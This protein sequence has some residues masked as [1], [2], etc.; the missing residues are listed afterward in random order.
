MEAYVTNGQVTGQA[1]PETVAQ[2]L[3]Q[4]QSLRDRIA[5]VE[6]EL[7]G[8]R[9]DPAL[10]AELEAL[11]N[12]LQDRVIRELRLTH[13]D[14]SQASHAVVLGE[15]EASLLQDKVWQMAGLGALIGLALSLGLVLWWRPGRIKEPAAHENLVKVPYANG[16]VAYANDHEAIFPIDTKARKIPEGSSPHHNPRGRLI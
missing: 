16:P 1:A 4:E 8:N 13:G 5:D 14:V 7:R 12:Y 15:A 10:L 2:I 11:T 6:R 9:D 3:E